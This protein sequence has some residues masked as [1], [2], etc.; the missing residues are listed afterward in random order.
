[1]EAFGNKIKDGI[2]PKNTT[3]VDP[4]LLYCGDEKLRGSDF[5]RLHYC[6]KNFNDILKAFTLCFDLTVVN[7]WHGILF[8]ASNLL[9]T[10]K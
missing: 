2:Y 7:Q 4:S 6:G 9:L 10:S 1:M 8:V 3:G 5:H